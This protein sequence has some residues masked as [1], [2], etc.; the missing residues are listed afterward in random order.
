MIITGALFVLLSGAWAWGIAPLFIK[1]PPDLK[2]VT[3]Y[4]GTLTLFAD[5]VTRRFFPPGQEK[6]VPLTI[7]AEDKS[8][9]EKST[10]RILVVDE[11]VAVKDASTGLPMVGVRPDATCVLDRRTSENVP[12]YI[13]G[14]ERSGWSL[15]FPLGARKKGYPLWDDELK[16]TVGADFVREEKMDGNK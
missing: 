11:H 1:L 7:H 3:D 9:P 15:T 16:R 14:V 10:S 13:E 4:R 2:V 6:V 8:V 12:G 5:E